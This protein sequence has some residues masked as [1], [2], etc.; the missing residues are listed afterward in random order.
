LRH[1]PANANAW[2]LVGLKAVTEGRPADAVEPLT[3]ALLLD[4]DFKGAYVNLGLAYLRLGN[5]QRS[6]DVSVAGQARH[7]DV[8]QFDYHIGVAYCQLALNMVNSRMATSDEM[9]RATARKAELEEAARLAV[10]EVEVCKRAEEEARRAVR[11]AKSTSDRRVA[12]IEEGTPLL[13]LED[14]DVFESVESE[15]ETGQLR[16]GSKVEAAG[17]PRDSAGCTWV[18]IQP[19]GAVN[20]R[21]VD[22]HVVNTEE[23]RALKEKDAKLKAAADARI[24]A[25]TR[26][27][28]ARAAAQE[29]VPDLRLRPVAQLLP[30]DEFGRY[31][32][33]R[34]RSL[35]AFGQARDN[36]VVLGRR[37]FL[38]SPFLDV[39][40]EM[41]T[42]MSSGEGPVEIQLPQNLGWPSNQY[43]T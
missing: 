7:A 29:A 39:D 10:E 38:E 14:I 31:E 11:E 20:R 12:V 27:K 42:A 5:W 3:K 40:D 17:K 6:I 25:V 41:V 1:L 8:A 19:R 22:V 16:R 15:L 36:V 21:A 32:D 18:P 35:E 37:R 23:K 43:K 4:P 26:M 9:A 28:E 24:E 30:P 2:H 33:W 34:R 13:V